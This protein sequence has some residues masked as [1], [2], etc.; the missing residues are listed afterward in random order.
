MDI[1]K[2]NLDALKKYNI[3]LYDLINEG[4]FSWNE[5]ETLVE[6]SKKDEI[7]LAYCKGN[8]KTYLSS[9][10]NS[11]NE[12]KKI[13]QDKVDMPDVSVLYLFG[14]SNGD[15]V[16]E[17]LSNTE[18]CNCIVYEPKKSIF[19]TVL[20]NIDISDLLESNRL[21]IVV[22]EI[23]REKFYSYL[24]VTVLP[25]NVKTN[26]YFALPI[27]ERIFHEEYL[28]FLKMVLEKYENLEIEI[29]TMSMFGNKMCYNS[30]HN[31]QYLVGCKS[32]V[33]LY[34]TAPEGIPAIVVSAGPSLEKNLDLLKEVHNKAFV[35]AVDTAIPKVMSR[36]IKPDMII[37][38]DCAKST[39]HFEV[40]GI[41]DIPFMVDMSSNYDVLN[42]VDSNNY[43][44]YSSNSI[45]WDNMFRDA[46]S[47]IKMVYA[48]GSVAIDALVNMILFGFKKIILIG[49][50]LSFTNN[51]QYADDDEINK[52][53]IKATTFY[54]KDIYGNDVLTKK[55]Y[56]TFIR[57]I[58]EIAYNHR[59]IVEIIDATEGGAFKRNTTIMTLREAID[60]YCK[61]KFD[62]D[63]FLSKPKRLF[64]GDDK[65]IITDTII[66]MKSNMQNMKE[67]MHKGYK[68]AKE[69]KELLLNKKYN[70]ER[71]KKINKFI[72]ELDEDFL[73][74]DERSF[75]VG[76]EPTT[77]YEF[78]R[79]YYIE[80]EDH[81]K[82]SI[83]MYSKSEKYYKDLTASIKEI[84]KML[85][86]C[87]EDIQKGEK[88]A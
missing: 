53:E 14:I 17:F 60:K 21:R 63:E 10:Y 36:G 76:Y 49:Q 16:R 37:S 31:M 65:R 81:I 79:D 4:N 32:A 5:N 18:K 84:I 30:I 15:A 40:E 43:I 58:E 86:E 62:V 19:M 41:N 44:F 13:M 77:N 24:E 1:Y 88:N 74:M 23:N 8:Q 33:E 2:K 57:A 39:K 55:D 9:K 11:E 78:L 12:A 61:N 26:K 70:V 82:E 38:V 28:V 27:Y 73:D 80:E 87:Y 54:V 46:G 64:M 20:Q 68:L 72:Y 52:D 3:D 25:N 69:G 83:R 85:D 56:F 51:K 66:N 50:D 48:G 75:I 34:D 6:K 29:N 45:I 35:I 59:D 22:D 7:I 67:K 42:F 47:E 71:L